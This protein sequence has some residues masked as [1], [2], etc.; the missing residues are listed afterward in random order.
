MGK[1]IFIAGKVTG[2]PQHQV[3]E[4]FSRAANDLSGKGYKVVSPDYLEQENS[5]WEDITRENIRHMLDCEEVHLLPCWQESRGA[6]LER[7]IAI[8]LGMNVVYH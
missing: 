5:N 1:K 3:K 4:K 8:R 2:L 7:D 6:Q